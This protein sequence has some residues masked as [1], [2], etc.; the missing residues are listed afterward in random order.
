MLTHKHAPEII[1]A[2]SAAI[3]GLFWIP[4]RVFEGYGLSP[5]WVTFSQ[6]LPPLLVLLPFAVMRKIRG[7]SVGIEQ[8]A[9]GILVGTAFVLYCESLLLTDVVRALILFYVMPAWGTL[10]EIGLMGRRFTL[11][12]GVALLLSIG[13]LLCIL[14]VGSDLDLSLNSGDIMA[15]LSGI[16]FTF[17][18]MRIRQSDKVAVFEQVFAFFLFGSLIAGVFTLLPLDVHA[19]PPSL[20]MISHLAPWLFVM[21]VGFLI[22]VITGMYWGSQF[23]D[24]GRLGILLQ[25]EAIIG[26][27]T[28]ALLLNEPFGWREGSGAMLVISAGVVEVFGHRRQNSASIDP[29]TTR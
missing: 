2:L 3:W 16:L 11:A 23:V 18:A 17:G 20:E 27:A 4:L 12:R 10:V 9:T 19:G 28:A 29:A 24:P 21:A 15:L 22:P 5:E 6:F 1:V 14:G 13:G 7:D 26:I 8:W 25:L